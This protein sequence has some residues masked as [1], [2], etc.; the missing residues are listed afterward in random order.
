M[1][2]TFVLKSCIFDT[3]INIVV[4]L[5]YLRAL[6]VKY[7]KYQSDK[8]KDMGGE[9]TVNIILVGKHEAKLLERIDG[10]E[11]NINP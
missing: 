10:P 9:M 11:D 1:N 5:K 6:I 7:I 2:K 3:I 4:I 8:I